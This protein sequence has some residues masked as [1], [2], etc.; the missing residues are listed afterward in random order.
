MR[1]SPVSDRRHETVRLSIDAGVPNGGD[2][3]TFPVVF[4]LCLLEKNS[5]TMDPNKL[6]FIGI[7]APG[8][9]SPGNLELTRPIVRPVHAVGRDGR[10]RRAKQIRALSPVPRSAR[11]ETAG[12]GVFPTSR[13]PAAAIVETLLK[14]DDTR[15]VAV[16]CLSRL[17]QRR[18]DIRG[19]VSTY[20]DAGRE[21]QNRAREP[22]TRACSGYRILTNRRRTA[23]P[24]PSACRSFRWRRIRFDGESD[25]T[26]ISFLGEKDLAGRGLIRRGWKRSKKTNPFENPYP[27]ATCRNGKQRAVRKKIARPI[28]L[29]RNLPLWQNPPRPGPRGRSTR[30]SCSCRDHDVLRHVGRHTKNLHSIFEKSNAV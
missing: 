2:D 6:Q 29:L 7:R 13:F 4:A 17:Q 12:C 1:S 21:R 3:T 19:A 24:T 25:A 27:A 18:G 9:A 8:P 14:S 5:Q 15:S 30:Y 26:M 22:G 10:G 28:L 11:H 20:Q 23:S 16:C